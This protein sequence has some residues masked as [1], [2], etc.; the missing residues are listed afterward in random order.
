MDLNYARI[1]YIVYYII[2]VTSCVT[3]TFVAGKKNSFNNKNTFAQ[4]NCELFSYPTNFSI[5][6]GRR[7]SKRTMLLRI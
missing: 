7:T 3:Y 2:Y 5:H 1:A 6:T 4:E